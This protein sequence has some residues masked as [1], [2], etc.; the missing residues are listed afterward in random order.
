MAKQLNRDFIGC[1]ASEEYYEKSM[2][3]LQNALQNKEEA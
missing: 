1:E 2:N 3:R